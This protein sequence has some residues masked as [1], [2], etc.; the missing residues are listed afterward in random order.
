MDNVPLKI[1]KGM[2]GGTTISISLTSQQASRIVANGAILVMST[3]GNG[4]KQLFFLG[5]RQDHPENMSILSLSGSGCTVKYTTSDGFLLTITNP[6]TWAGIA[7]TI[8]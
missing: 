3:N 8:F 2:N 5:G 1:N 7:L 6:E 4:V